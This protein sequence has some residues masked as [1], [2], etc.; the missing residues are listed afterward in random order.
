LKNTEEIGLPTKK[1][2]KLVDP[3]TKADLIM[4]LYKIIEHEGPNYGRM[5]K[6]AKALQ[7]FLEEK[8]GY[9]LG[10]RFTDP[11]IY[12]VWDNQ[13]QEDIERYDA[14]DRLVNNNDLPIPETIG[15]YSHKLELRRPDGEFLLSTVSKHNLEK[16][17]KIKI[18]VLFEEI[19]KFCLKG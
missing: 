3:V 2:L 16:K 5:H 1:E 13:F 12:D 7:D 17:F 11:S 19:K 6:A 10:Y 4:L 15:Y 14:L 9:T 8:Y 18:D